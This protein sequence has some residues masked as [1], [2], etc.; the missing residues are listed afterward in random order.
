MG[1]LC[2][3]EVACSASERQGSN[4]EYCDWRAVSSHHHQKVLPPSLVYVCTKVSLFISFYFP[5]ISYDYTQREL[6]IVQKPQRMNTHSIMK[7]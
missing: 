7:L 6:S 3:R 4:F 2:D 5:T 1:S